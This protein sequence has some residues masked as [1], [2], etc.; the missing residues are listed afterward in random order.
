MYNTIIR[1]TMIS[2]NNENEKYPD[3]YLLIKDIDEPASDM[4]IDLK[5]DLCF[6]T[7]FSLN[8]VELIK[9]IE[10]LQELYDFCNEKNIK[11]DK[12][13][14]H[15]KGLLVGGGRDYFIF[16]NLI[17]YGWLDCDFQFEAEEHRKEILDDLDVE[18][19]EERL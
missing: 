13:L 16:N 2:K 7:E 11:L 10:S 19:E 1:C 15:E 6:N 5:G 12:S 18:I 8:E 3:S 14:I 9:K 4:D 17:P